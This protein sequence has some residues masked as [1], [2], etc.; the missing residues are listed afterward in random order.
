M[1]LTTGILLG[2]VGALAL[3]ALRDRFFGTT[4]VIRNFPVI[5]HIRYWLISVGPEL[6]QYLVAHNREEKP[7]NRCQRQWIEHTADGSNNF[8]GF[9]TDA[10]P[11]VSGYWIIKHSQTPYGELSFADKGESHK[12]YALPCAKT[13]GKWHKRPNPYQPPSL[14]NISAMSFGALSARAVSSLNKGAKLANCYQ[15]TGE[16]GLAPY[17]EFGADVIYQIG[18]GL[19][20]CRSAE[21]RFDA[22]KLK[23]L[24]ARVPQVKAIE[25]KL[26]QGA[27][28][29]K[30]GVLP[31]KKVSAEIALIRTV[32]EGKDCISPNR[33][34]EFS[35]P[36]ELIAFIE[37]VAAVSQRPVGIK[38]AIGA[39]EFW[40]ELADLMAKDQ[41]RGP[42]FI[43]ID[44]GEG[45]TGAA[46]LA[47]ADHVSLPFKVAF[48][49]VY[50]IF[51]D[52]G[53]ADK[54]VWIGSA[55]LGF[56]D[57]ALVAFAMGVDSINIAR[58][59]ML[60]IGCIQAQKCHTNHCPTGV[61]TQS[62]WLQRGIDVERQSHHLANYIDGF[63]KEL[64]ALAH[65]CGYAHPSQIKATDIEIGNGVYKYS[66][67]SEIIGYEPLRQTDDLH[68]EHFQMPIMQ[69]AAMVKRHQTMRLTKEDMA[70]A[71]N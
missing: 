44:G 38:S 10:E 12:S 50:K 17:H 3:L 7:F 13:I 11:Y 60:S 54:V 51:L 26:S 14:I 9:G 41:T 59:A 20:G 36:A 8:F 47:F 28:P 1:D 58:E 24:V 29:G 27:K 34:V 56:P 31:G 49:R 61:A 6:R 66:K 53:I 2:I 25:I 4:S 52:K 70:R 18:T 23:A 57:R 71:R 37:K 46:P 33:H 19:F 69:E 40:H 21:G 5:G 55:K 48:P 65:A 68:T 39:L 22:E 15:N 62:K 67:L 32:Q 30:G 63:R 42:D 64:T 16:G 35:T 45:G 43:T